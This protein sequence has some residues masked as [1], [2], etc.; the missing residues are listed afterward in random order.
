MCFNPRGDR[1]FSVGDDK[2]ILVWD[3]EKHF[4]EEDETKKGQKP[5]DNILCKVQ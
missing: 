5:L 2:Q 1:L 3:A 4:E